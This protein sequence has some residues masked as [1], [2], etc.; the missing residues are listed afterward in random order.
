MYSTRE[1]LMFE[2]W[3]K[4]KYH[5][6]PRKMYSFIWDADLVEFTNIR[7]LYVYQYFDLSIWY[8]AGKEPGG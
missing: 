3:A 8:K 4:Y 5:Q 1:S 7:S 2:N 6:K